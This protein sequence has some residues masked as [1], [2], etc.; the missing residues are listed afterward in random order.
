MASVKSG[1]F[2]NGLNMD[3]DVSDFRCSSPPSFTS[4]CTVVQMTTLATLFAIRNVDT[5]WGQANIE[6]MFSCGEFNRLS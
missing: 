1:C 6:R 4:W 3:L 2:E 5:L